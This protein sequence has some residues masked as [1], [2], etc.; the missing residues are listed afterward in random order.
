MLKWVACIMTIGGSLGM[1]MWYREQLLE[2]IWVL[3]KLC[4]ITEL[5]SGEIR[6]QRKTLPECCRTIAESLEKPYGEWFQRI[7]QGC[8]TE[9]GE[10]LGE[11][12][13]ECLETGLKELPVTE[14]DR[15]AFLE[16]IPVRSYFDWEMQ[17]S[18]LEKSRLTL[19]R[20]I[21]DLEADCKQKGKLAPAL[22]L[23]C[24]LVLVIVLV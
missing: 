2:R 8:R 14:E 4:W 22:G 3:R 9:Q 19:Q 15:R 6:F 23:G 20:R 10:E 5:V 1:G 16:F 18:S 17:I 12:M 21:Q 7:H 11:W 13:R 24:G